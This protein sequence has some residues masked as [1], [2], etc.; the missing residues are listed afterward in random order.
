VVNGLDLN[1]SFMSSN[2][3]GLASSNLL[4]FTKKFI[5]FE[6]VTNIIKCQCRNHSTM[7]SLKPRYLFAEFAAF[8]LLSV[9]IR[10]RVLRYSFAI[11]LQTREL[12]LPCIDVGY[13]YKFYGS[14]MHRSALDF[15]SLLYSNSKS[16]SWVYFLVGVVLVWYTQRNSVLANQLPAPLC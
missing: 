1:Y 12:Q 14:P 13:R 2:G 8:F 4:V 7:A 9:A 16:R 15:K 3:F 5:A 11:E 10:L 6:R